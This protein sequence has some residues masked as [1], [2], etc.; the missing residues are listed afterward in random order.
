MGILKF[1]Q[2]ESNENDFDFPTFREVE[3]YFYDFTDEI[4]SNLYGYQSGFKFY[5]KP[6]PVGLENIRYYKDRVSN[7]SNFI[8]ILNTD[9]PDK[10]LEFCGNYCYIENFNFAEHFASK[11]SLEAI[12]GGAKAYKHLM[13][14]FAGYDMDQET[15]RYYGPT[16]FPKEKLDLLI[17][18]LKRFYH[19]EGFRPYGDLWTEDYVKQGGAL[20][21][22]A[23]YEVEEKIGFSGLLVNCSDEE[24]IKMSQL[25]EQ[26]EGNKKLI[27]HFI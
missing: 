24:Y 15:A 20:G 13:I 4:D 17:E 12:K 25:I 2:F 7:K 6:Y 11:V 23:S 14:Q 27:Q 18:C 8:D 1:K 5:L 19:A 3:S 22:L 9:I 16:L 10:R 21:R 26:R